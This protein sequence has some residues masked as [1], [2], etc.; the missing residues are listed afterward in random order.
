VFVTGL[1]DGENVTIAYSNAGV[2]L[3][4]NFYNEP[5]HSAVATA[6]AVDSS[7]DVFV[8][9]DSRITFG[10]FADY[11]TIKYSHLGVPLWTNRY[12]GPGNSVDSVQAIA[13]DYSGNAFVT[14]HSIGSGSGFDYATIAYSNA[15]VP[16][17][18]NRYNGPDNRNDY[19]KAIAVD[20]SG[21][22]FV[23]GESYGANRSDYTTI[24]YS[25]A[26]VP[27]WT[28]HYAGPGND[29]DLV[30]AIAIDGG[31]NVFVTGQSYGTNDSAYATI[32]YSNTGV[33][34]WTNRYNITASGY[35]GANAIAV[36]ECGNVFV[37]GVSN[38]DGDSYDYATIKYSSMSSCPN[39]SPIP[40]STQIVGNRI[41]LSWTNGAFT[42]QS[43]PTVDGTY[44]NI[45]GATS[46]Y[47]NLDSGTQQFF[48]LQAN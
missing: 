3:W 8:T 29:D 18:T 39:P 9:G 48:R 40:L 41:V 6:I 27:L 4:T 35:D 20:S 44:T 24:A 5:D 36:D 38:G 42:L 30:N 16:L 43:A 22:V 37:T 12:N 17:W 13:V 34:L 25:N 47:T 21:K 14:G 7:G 33:P 15:G 46:P 31:G 26:G 10:G 11:A 1:S 32:A 19:A 45:S 28:N 2:P 23:T